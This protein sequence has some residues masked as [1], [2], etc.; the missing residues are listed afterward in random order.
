[1][2]ETHDG[3]EAMQKIMLVTGGGRGIGAATCRLAAQR[4][5][6]VA[7]NY[8]QNRAAAQALADEI[9]RAGG[10]AIAVQADVADEAQVAAMFRTVDEE[11]GRLDVLVNNA[12]IV[13]TAMRFDEMD[14]ARWRRMFEVNVIGAM[15]CAKQAVLRMSTRHGG[16]GGAI[17]NL[18]SGAARLGSP[19][20][21]VD[22]ASAKGAVDTFTVGLGRE[23]GGEGIRV[24]AVRP[25]VVDTEIH[26][27]SGDMG[28]VQ[29]QAAAI[30]VQRAGRPEEIAEAILW[31]ASDAASF[32]L[33][34]IIDATGGR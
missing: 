25:G 30:P 22:Y 17:V 1:M 7:I 2:A 8:T 21:Y 11:L 3:E 5:Y 20:R 15:N 10:K 33:A 32:T 12:G 29:Q 16:K 9:A 23:V 4:G 6:A 19:G 13:D 24:N 28:F 18:T 26:A 31:V 34:A 27:S 14:A